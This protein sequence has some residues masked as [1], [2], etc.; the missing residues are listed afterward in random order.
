[1]LIAAKPRKRLVSDLKEECSMFLL[2]AVW[3]KRQSDEIPM[4]DGVIPYTDK[5]IKYVRRQR[6]GF[7]SH[8]G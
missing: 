7:P 5:L 2:H 6:I 1:M 4:W 8:F 3:G